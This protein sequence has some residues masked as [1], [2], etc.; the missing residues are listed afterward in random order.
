MIDAIELARKRHTFDLWAY[1]V[2]PEHVH[3]LI[4][5][6]EAEYSISGIL[7]TLKQPVSKRAILHVRRE[8]PQFL[9]RMTN[10]QPNGRTSIHFWQRGG[11]YDRNL[12][13]PRHIWDTIDYIHANPPRRELCQR[14]EQWQWSSAAAY[15]RGSADPLRVDTDSLPDDPRRK[16]S[17]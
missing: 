13:S 11:G 10:R 1:V 3:L 12:W 6:T 15:E 7:T 8:A 16:G 2:M 4:R 9:E 17:W 14:P 5:P